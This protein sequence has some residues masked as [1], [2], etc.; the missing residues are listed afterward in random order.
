MPA[1]AI[2]TAAEPLRVMVRPVIAR[3]VEAVLGPWIT[4][5]CLEKWICPGGSP[6]P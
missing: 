2:P 6:S 3:S 5:E 4:P 1:P